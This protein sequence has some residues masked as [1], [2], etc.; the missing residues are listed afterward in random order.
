MI[1]SCFQPDWS[2]LLMG[3]TL[4][5]A[6]K[7][8]LP[9]TGMFTL[10]AHFPISGAD[11]R[12]EDSS[13]PQPGTPWDFSKHGTHSKRAAFYNGTFISTNTLTTVNEILIIRTRRYP[14]KD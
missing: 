11:S 3:F 14:A 10:C 8:S 13:Q 9:H 1:T 7:V 6:R 2:R 5:R 12:G 4:G